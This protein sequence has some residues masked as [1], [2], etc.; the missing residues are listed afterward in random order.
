MKT[1]IFLIFMFSEIQITFYIV[2]FN[3]YFYI[4]K[5]FQIYKE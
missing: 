2:L 5:F 3:L 4:W 1:Y